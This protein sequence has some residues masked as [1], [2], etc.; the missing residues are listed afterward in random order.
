MTLPQFNAEAALRPTTGMY[1]RNIFAVGA[2]ADAI[3]PMQD[4]SAS[5]VASPSIATRFGRR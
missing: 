5:S 3:L 4:F 1:L 2:R